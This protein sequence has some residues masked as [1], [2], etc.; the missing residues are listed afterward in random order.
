MCA[1]HAESRAAL[2][3]VMN[4]GLSVQTE[5]IKAAHERSGLS[6]NKLL[7][8]LKDHTGDNHTQGKYWSV[9]I[10]DKNTHTYKVNWPYDLIE[11]A[12]NSMGA[13]N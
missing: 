8:A 10:G 13:N 9:T 5:I 3:D 1:K 6:M 7:K 12:E 4:G 11:T 2:L